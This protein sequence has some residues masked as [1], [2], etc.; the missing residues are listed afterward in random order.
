MALKDSYL[1]PVC[2]GHLR[3][4]PA[5]EAAKHRAWH[6]TRPD[7]ETNPTWLF[8]ASKG[9]KARMGSW[10]RKAHGPTGR[11]LKKEGLNMKRVNDALGE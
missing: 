5:S 8:G 6:R 1:C 9:N 3:I 2:P 7:R 11:K 4:S 10:K